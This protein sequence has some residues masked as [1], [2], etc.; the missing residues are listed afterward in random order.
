MSAIRFAHVVARAVV[1]RRATLT[2]L[3]HAVLLP[4]NAIIISGTIDA[5]VVFHPAALLADSLAIRIVIT[6]DTDLPIP[7]TNL[8]PLGAAGGARGLGVTVVGL[9]ITRT[10]VSTTSL[11]RLVN[12]ER[13]LLVATD[14]RPATND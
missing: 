13:E 2:G 3:R 7:V 8:V 6:F 5:A 11:D 14:N 1:A 12:I 10:C 9:R 4:G